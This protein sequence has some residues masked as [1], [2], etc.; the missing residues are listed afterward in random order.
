MKFLDITNKLVS[1]LLNATSFVNCVRMYVY[2]D[3]C[4]HMHKFFLKCLL[5]FGISFVTPN[6]VVRAILN[7]FIHPIFFCRDFYWLK[8]ESGRY[9][10]AP[11]NFNSHFFP[12]FWC[13]AMS[14]MLCRLGNALAH[15][16]FKSGH[17][18][19][20]WNRRPLAYLAYTYE[21]P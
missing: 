19:H 21:L 14:Q 11:F 18:K 17:Y 8:H 10:L 5:F 20:E 16:A 9:T 2:M 12:L 6:L 7:H 15:Y 13:G 4:D 1:A 3:S